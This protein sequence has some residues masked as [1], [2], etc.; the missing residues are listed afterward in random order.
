MTTVKFNISN[1][2]TSGQSSDN[3]YISI[4][5]TDPST[6]NYSYLDFSSG[7]LVAFSSYVSG[8]T[9]IALSNV[10]GSIDVP[11]IKS[12][13]MYIAAGGDFDATNF[14]AGSGPSPSQVNDG[15]APLIFDFVE[16]DTSSPGNYNINSSNV[17]MYAI[18][19][20]MSLADAD[21]KQVTRGLS[22]T[23]TQILNQLRNI[24]VSDATSFYQQLFVTDVNGNLL[25]FL[26]PQ[27][28]AYMDVAAGYHLPMTNYFR[29]YLQTQVF[30]PNRSFSFYDKQYPNTSNLCTA[31]VSADG[32]TMTIQHNDNG[33]P[34]T[35][36]LTQ[37][38][39]DMNSQ[40]INSYWHNVSGAAGTIDW[41]FMLFGNSLVPTLPN[42]WG[43]TDPF[44]GGPD[45]AIMALLVSIV[46]GVAHM[47][48]GCTDWVNSNNYYGPVMTEYY[49]KIIHANALD[50]FAYALAYDDVYGKNSSVSFNSGA[51]VSFTLKSLETVQPQ[52]VMKLTQGSNVITK[53]LEDL[54]RANNGKFSMSFG[55]LP[56][57][58]RPTKLE[59]CYQG[60]APETKIEMNFTQGVP[61][62]S[63][64]VT[65]YITNQ[66]QVNNGS[67][68]M[69]FP[70]NAAPNVQLNTIEF[71]FQQN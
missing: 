43:A 42:G 7:Q 69:T 56:P 52:T 18:T 45:N 55:S 5:G 14:A 37:P 59:F 58:Q 57:D 66:L 51:K 54:I 53:H 68:T 70:Q 65:E 30:R 35:V 22:G 47:D 12:A 41:G 26:A 19:Y 16:F 44:Y 33:S 38:V 9:S 6:G 36:T 4:L 64:S 61:Q 62:S 39:N 67:F 15:G 50:N 60:V 20:T 34:E 71:Q 24:P 48:N 2:A 27:Q 17:D 29:N 31:T 13:R 11:V 23:R 49:A 10:S 40:Q 32:Q 25:R 21:G 46:R 1:A 28:A 63:S 3:V 8:T